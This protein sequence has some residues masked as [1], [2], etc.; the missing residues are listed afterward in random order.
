VTT[1]YNRF[2]RGDEPTE[3]PC[4]A[5]AALPGLKELGLSK[6]GEA[7]HDHPPLPGRRRDSLRGVAGVGAGER[8]A[9]WGSGEGGV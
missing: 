2:C 6:D 3:R 8:V 4:E 9:G 7:G 1:G 5:G